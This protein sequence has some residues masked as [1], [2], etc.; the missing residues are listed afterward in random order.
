MDTREW[1]DASTI[2]G[3]APQELKQSL[4]DLICA[5]AKLNKARGT[6]G[7]EP[8]IASRVAWTEISVVPKA[9]EPERPEGRVV[10]EITVEEDMLNGNGTMHG[11]CSALLIDK[12]VF[13]AVSNTPRTLFDHAHRPSQP[14]NDRE[15][16]PRR[17]AVPQHSVPRTRRDVR[18][19]TR[20][21]S[22]LEC[23]DTLFLFPQ[24]RQVA[25]R[26]HYDITR[27]SCSILTL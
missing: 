15:R 27:Q 24:E 3:S 17:L 23:A 14:G 1:I 10:G 18:L 21:V 6:R 26:E 11:A 20:H 9:E 16:R 22:V 7:F 19:S 2:S 5:Q 25:R 8:E 4:L 13:D 12:C